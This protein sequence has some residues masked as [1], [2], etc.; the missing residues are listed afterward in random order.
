M[1]STARAFSATTMTIHQ[2]VND[3][4]GG[5]ASDPKFTR[6]RVR[7]YLSQYGFRGSKLKA[8][9][10]RICTFNRSKGDWKYPY[11]WS[12]QDLTGPMR[13]MFGLKRKR[14]LVILDEFW[15]LVS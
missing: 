13:R 10:E 9:V 1:L 14:N 8:E 12:E 6:T 4:V 15:S 7:R 5:P 3:F 11:G 2:D